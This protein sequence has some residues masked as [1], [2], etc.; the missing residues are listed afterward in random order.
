MIFAH[1][2]LL[3]PMLP[4]KN[5]LNTSILLLCLYFATPATQAYSKDNTGAL[6]N[7]AKAEFNKNEYNSSLSA[8]LKY[9]QAQ[10]QMKSHDTIRL[11]DA[12]YNVGGI[13]SLYS[14]Y[15]QALEIYKKGYSLSVDAGNSEMQFKF[16]NNMVGASCEIGDVNYAEYTNN[17]I[18]QLKGINRG[19]IAYF[20]CFNKGFIAGNRK[21]D[22]TKA[23]WMKKVLNIVDKYKLPEE[24]KIYAYSEIYQ[25]YEN[26]GN[27]T[28]A[29]VY[30]HKYDSLAHVTNHAFL[31]VDCYKGLMR[32][33]TKMGDKERALHYQSE[34]FRY[35]D[36]LLNLNEFSKIKTNYQTNE[37]KRTT[38]TINNLEKTNSQQQAMLLML[39]MI[40]VI[41]VLAVVVVYR[42]RQKLHTANVELFRRNSELLEAERRYR[43]SM[44]RKEHKT[45][46][47][48]AEEHDDKAA[49]ATGHDDLL[50]KILLVMED[51][52]T[53]CNPDFNLQTLARMTESNTNYVS[54]TINSTFGKNFR[55]FVNEYRI[56][57]AMKRMMDN[58]HYGNYSIQ[59]ISE[60]V[61]Y[62]SASNFIA[63]FKKMTGMTPSLYQKIS[64]SSI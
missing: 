38:N 26:K 59:G 12:Y 27:L 60:S 40:V 18:R 34:Y 29:L 1:Q 24:M 49:T 21:D 30:L 55:S 31:Y 57:V 11:T 28:E 48:G 13:Y 7:K 2:Y 44:E 53:F 15:A 47:D 9:I 5:I 6:Y 37:K 33:Y 41:A 56:K 51:E 14:D 52:E 3:T 10:E 39:V 62:K 16:L 54:Q 32:I 42:Q 23:L 46:S 22:S 61:G 35:A 45:T 64:K 20:Y 58:E 43:M 17:K 50:Q 63:A 25:C 19:K 4:I 8:F 36:S